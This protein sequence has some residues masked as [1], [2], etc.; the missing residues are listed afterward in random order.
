MRTAF[1]PRP[2]SEVSRWAARVLAVSL[3][4]GGCAWRSKADHLATPPVTLEEA[5]ELVPPEVKERDGW[6]RDVLAALEANRVHPDEEA[7]CSV[8][9]VIEQESGFDP[10]PGV[11]DLARIARE[12]LEEKAR[13]F[14]PMGEKATEKLLEGT[15]R[16]STRTFGER[17]KS[18]RTERD[19]DRLF[20]DML[21][22]YR[23]EFPTAYALVNLASSAG[24]RGGV[25]AMNPIT[26]AGCMQVS[27][28][29]ALELAR[30]ENPNASEW[31]VRER[32]YTRAGG[33]F[34]G[35]SRLLDYEVNYEDPLYRFADYNAGRYASRNAALQ[36]QLADLI[37]RKLAL[38]GDLLAYDAGGEPSREDSRTLQA[39]VEF[40]AKYVPALTEA[41]IRRDLL[42]EKSLELEQT[43][44]WRSLK[45]AW[46]LKHGAPAPY[47][48][49][50]DVALRSPKM[51]KERSTEWFARAVD[52][53][54]RACLARGRTAERGPL[55]PP[56]NG[57]LARPR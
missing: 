8:L 35:T 9:A 47:A 13:E 14:G 40:A 38:D 54:F 6:A 31:D 11:P 25:E 30:K 20:R 55:Q 39:F 56:S 48:R 5:T 24:G 34:F 28:R 45:K 44:T 21:D 4:A 10:N 23:S 7:V 37:G 29:Y 26:T 42:K 51:K 1:C 52:R 46:E 12:Q 41:D 27:V 36:E 22:Y 19:L 2:L 15:A 33:V 50:P 16:G 43:L 53:R 57:A 32:L 18:V 17:L 3:L 49:L